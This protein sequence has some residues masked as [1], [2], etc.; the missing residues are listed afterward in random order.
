MSNDLLISAMAVDYL[1]LLWWSKT[2][3]AETNSNRPK[4]LLLRL[5]GGKEEKLKP[6][7]SFDTAEDFTKKFREITEGDA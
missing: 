1:A 4:S 5:T 7:M 3:D 6:V 2:K